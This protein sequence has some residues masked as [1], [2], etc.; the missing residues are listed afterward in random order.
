[1]I[2]SNVFIS[3][4]AYITKTLPLETCAWPIPT[5]DHIP[6]IDMDNI[7]MAARRENAAAILKI[8]FFELD[9]DNLHYNNSLVL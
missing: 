9:I 2:S 8:L 6:S 3:E 7:K 1:M 5:T 4:A